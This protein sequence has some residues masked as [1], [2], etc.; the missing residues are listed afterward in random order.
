MY[1]ISNYKP[2]IR[3]CDAVF[4]CME[5]HIVACRDCST[6]H[7]YDHSHR[8]IRFD[9]FQWMPKLPG[10]DASKPCQQCANSAKIRWECRSCGLSLCFD[11]EHYPERREAFFEQHTKV[12]PESRQFVA[13]YPPYANTLSM[14]KTDPCPCVDIQPPA[15]NVH[16]WRCNSGKLSSWSRRSI[17]LTLEMQSL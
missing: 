14:W 7:D 3:Y 1:S 5:C 4:F 8:T 12:D 6:S 9:A 15:I 2:G 17:T 10:L 13:I 11:C 16:C